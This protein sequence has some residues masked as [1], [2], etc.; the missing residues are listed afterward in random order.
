MLPVVTE[1]RPIMQYRTKE[2]IKNLIRL[3]INYN[4]VFY[5]RMF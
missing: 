5:S 4:I 3:D 1:T 2:L